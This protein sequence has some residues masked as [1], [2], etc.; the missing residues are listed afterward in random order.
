MADGLIIEN[1]R[2]DVALAR[3]MAT[4][5]REPEVVLR[6]Q[7]KTVFT[8]VAKVTPPAGEGVF[9]KPAEKR[10]VAKVGSDI[11]SLYGTPGD[12][13]D[14][15]AKKSRAMA[16]TFWFLNESGDTDAAA[17]LVRSATSRSF[18]PFDG[19]TLHERTQGG[20]RRR[21]RGRREIIFYVTD[22]EKLEDY[23]KEEQSHVWWLA[24]GWHV[25]LNELGAKLPYGV[26][27]HAGPGDIRIVMDDTGISITMTNAVN[28]GREVQGI[29]RRIQWAMNIQ[30]R[31]LDRAYEHFMARAGK[32]AG[33]TVR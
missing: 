23:I 4:S 18:A 28:Y 17:D 24:S 9:G 13:Y 2:L 30:A 29:E 8:R 3:L 7:A 31:N 15:I 21:S 27:K 32:G 16:S 19:G 11:R 6:A 25:A 14:A 33:F 12:A 26:D 20:R 10:A 1:D 22:P 5:K